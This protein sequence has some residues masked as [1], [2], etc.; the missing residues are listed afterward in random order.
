MTAPAVA[1]D[2]LV[3]A[4]AG[5]FLYTHAGLGSGSGIYAFSISSQTGALTALKGNPFDSPQIGP[6]SLAISVTSASGDFILLANQNSNQMSVSAINA[7]NG[8][9][10]TVAGSPFPGGGITG[11]IAAEPTGKFVYTAGNLSVSGFAMNNTTVPGALTPLIPI[12]QF[13]SGPGTYVLVVRP[14]P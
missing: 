4:P 3:A 6:S 10:S 12:S 13:I 2:A 11:Q 1:L 5:G 7:Q 9:L 8:P 14:S